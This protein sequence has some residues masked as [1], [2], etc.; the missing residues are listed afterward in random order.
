MTARRSSSRPSAPCDLELVDGRRQQAGER[1]AQAVLE[2]DAHDA[3]GRAPQAV[4]VARARR[5]LAGDPRADDVV[6]LVGDGEQ[7]AGQRARQR[8]RGRQRAVV[9]AHGRGDRV[10]Q[11]AGLRVDAAHHAL[12]H[13]ELDD[14]LAHEVGLGQAR[15]RAQRLGE[16]RRGTVA[17]AAGA[18]GAGPGGQTGH[19]PLQAV[20]LVGQRAELLVEHHVAEP[21]GH[22]LEALGDVAVVGELG[23]VEPAFEHALV[24]ARD[25]VGRRGIG[26][27][28]VE[29]R[30]QQ[31][32]V[33]VAHR[34]VALVALHGRDEHGRGQAQVAVGEAP[35]GRRSAT[36][37]G[38]PPRRARRRGR[39]T[40]RRARRRARR[41]LRRSGGGARAARRS[42][43][44]PRGASRSARPCR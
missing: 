23:V 30:R 19:Q 25:E 32:A 16:R 12:Q 20:R 3:H 21:V 6:G 24:A 8:R 4:R 2:R 13:G 29:E 31:A 36:R 1:E 39:T 17:A 22:G 42:P 7:G 41:A 9:L 38:T 27:A 37:R 26:V 35:R 14:H 28:H 18:C 40:R 33:A 11:T 43:S 44:A 5:L 10:A 15:R 34:E